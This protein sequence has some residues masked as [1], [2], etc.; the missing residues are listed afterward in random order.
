MTWP[1]VLC[2]SISGRL[3]SRST[4]LHHPPF[5][6]SQVFSLQAPAKASTTRKVPA[7]VD[8]ASLLRGAI[9][10]T[11]GSVLEPP[12]CLPPL[13]DS[14]SFPPHLLLREIASNPG[15]TKGIFSLRVDF[16]PGFAE[17]V[18]VPCRRIDR[19]QPSSHPLAHHKQS[20]SHQ[21]S[22]KRGCSLLIRPGSG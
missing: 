21:S 1:L 4:L 13:T 16:S 7:R 17:A 10:Y 19:D 18:R 2:E 11:L 8:F 3:S 22:L 5:S 14:Q 20:L 15:L 12:L 9:G 6:D